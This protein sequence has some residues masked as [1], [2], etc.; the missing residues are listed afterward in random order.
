MAKLAAEPSSP[1]S[2]VVLLSMTKHF[3]SQASTL[4]FKFSQ[5]SYHLQTPGLVCS[6][7][8]PLSQ[9]ESLIPSPFSQTWLEESIGMFTFRT[10]GR[11]KQSM[12]TLLWLSRFRL[13]GLPD[14]I[15][16]LSARDSFLYLLPVQE[17]ICLSWDNSLI[18]FGSFFS[19]GGG[20]KLNLQLLC[21]Q[22]YP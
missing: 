12:K 16:G 15:D 18:Y 9:L 8:K 19:S 22:S 20:V 13:T 6:V 17:V 10:K 14:R 5:P 11:Q 1:R 4:I 2:Q 21:Y 3:Q 7:L